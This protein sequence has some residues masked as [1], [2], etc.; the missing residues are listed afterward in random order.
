MSEDLIKYWETKIKNDL[1]PRLEA[2]SIEEKKYYDC[3]LS[4]EEKRMAINNPIDAVRLCP[5]KLS[6]DQAQKVWDTY[7]I[8]VKITA[9]SPVQ[10]YSK[11]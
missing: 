8:K 3:I 5:N 2:F 6:Q 1:A 7:C 10:S 4:W 9:T 11:V